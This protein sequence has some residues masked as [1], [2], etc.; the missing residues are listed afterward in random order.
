VIPK[1]EE[2]PATPGQI[3]ALAHAST[4][5]AARAAN[6]LSAPSDSSLLVSSLLVTVRY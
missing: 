2:E 4:L 3:P 1:E 5:V 6:S